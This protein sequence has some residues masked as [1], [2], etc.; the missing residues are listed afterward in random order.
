MGVSAAAL[1]WIAFLG[2]GGAL[3]AIREG[4][5]VPLAVFLLSALAF[6]YAGFRARRMGLTAAQSAQAGALAGLMAGLLSDFWRTATL[7]LSQPYMAWIQTSPHPNAALARMPP[8]PITLLAALIGVT[9]SAIAVGAAAGAIGGSLAE[10][11]ADPR[12]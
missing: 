3:G 11:P 5:L 12:P 6:A 8:V 10:K 2:L 7:F 4:T 1:A 9:A